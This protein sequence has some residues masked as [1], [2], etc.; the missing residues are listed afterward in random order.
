MCPGTDNKIFTR[1][2]KTGSLSQVLNRCHVCPLCCYTETQMIEDNT[3]ELMVTSPAQVHLSV[4]LSV[5]AGSH[6]AVITLVMQHGHLF[7][8]FGS[9]LF[10]FSRSRRQTVMSWRWTKR[11]RY[12]ATLRRRWSRSVQVKSRR[13]GSRF[14]LGSSVPCALASSLSVRSRCMRPTATALW[15]TRT[16][17]STRNNRRTF[18]RVSKS[19]FQF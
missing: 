13:G 2:R 17:T 4:L 6:G 10:S 15:R 16:Q 1:C 9:S 7:L 14:P 3:P 8:P 11:P 12:P 19:N 5:P 18:H